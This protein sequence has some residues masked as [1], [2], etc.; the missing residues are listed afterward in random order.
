MARSKEE[1]LQ[2]YLDHFVKEK[3]AFYFNKIKQDADAHRKE[4]IKQFCDAF[5]NLYA[6]LPE[7]ERGKLPLGYIHYS[8][9]LSHVLLRKPVYMAEA[10]GKDYFLEE[11]LASVSYHP[12]WLMEHLYSFYEDLKGEAKKYMFHMNEIE[13]EK[14]FL[15]EVRYYEG[16]MYQVARES[17]KEIIQSEEFKK[18]TYEEKIEF[19]IGEYCGDSKLLYIK[20]EK[21]E[22]MREKR[23]EILWNQ[24]G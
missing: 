14:V 22:Q 17:M 6:Q 10:Y 2:H 15:I 16:L 9:L 18:L 20:N 7:D 13:V 3:T 5:F 19:R 8:L 11:P 12:Q 24:S 21:T 1:A 4:I 23:H